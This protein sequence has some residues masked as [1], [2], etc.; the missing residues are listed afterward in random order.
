MMTTESLISNVVFFSYR[1][2]LPQGL[3]HVLFHHGDTRKQVYRYVYAQIS[4][5]II[6]LLHEWLVI[7][8]IPHKPNHRLPPRVPLA[9]GVVIGG[10]ARVV[11]EKFTT[12]SAVMRLPTELA[13]T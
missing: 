6:A 7:F 13:Q 3:V 10:V 8:Q 1:A 5:S 9:R 12:M 11:Y 2:E 4:V